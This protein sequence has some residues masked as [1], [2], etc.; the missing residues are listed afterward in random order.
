M[1]DAIGHMR[2]LGS[3]IIVVAHRPNILAHM[4][5]ILVL[6]EGE[7]TMFGPRDEVLEAIRA[8]RIAVLAEVPRS[9]R[10]VDPSREAE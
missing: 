8:P 2:D 4:D 5:K 1:M 9:T 10:P 7:V 3:T 6:K